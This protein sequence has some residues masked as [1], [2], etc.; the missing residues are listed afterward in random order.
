MDILVVFRLDL[1]QTAFNL[2]KNALA[3]QQLVF[4]ATG[5]T[6]CDILTRACAEIKILRFLEFFFCLSIFS[7][8]FLFAAVIDPL[9]GLLAVK[10]LLRKHHQEGQ[11]LPWSSQV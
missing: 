1:G 3:S 4:L 2:V 7:F 8:Y 9:L 5:I 11:F 6:F 10:R